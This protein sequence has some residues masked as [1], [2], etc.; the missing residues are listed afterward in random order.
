M[1]FSHCKDTWIPLSAT[2]IAIVK[3]NK[4]IFFPKWFFHHSLWG[5]KHLEISTLYCWR[6]FES[7]SKLTS[8]VWFWI[9]NAYTDIWQSFISLFI[10]LLKIIPQSWTSLEG[11][12]YTCKRNN[13]QLFFSCQ[14]GCTQEKGKEFA[15]PFQAWK[16]NQE[17]GSSESCFLFIKMERNTP[18]VPSPLQV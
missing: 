16:T 12:G 10:Y 7:R 6:E 15:L 5:S 1:V 2:T 11:N 17:T 3:V 4:K 9:W 8:L 18:F 14:L 13:C